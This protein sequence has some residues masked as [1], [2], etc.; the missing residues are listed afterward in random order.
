M[1]KMAYDKK[2]KKIDWTSSTGNGYKT[3]QKVRYPTK[4]SKHA[5]YKNAK[6]PKSTPK[7]TAIFRRQRVIRKSTK[8]RSPA[9]II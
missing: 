1:H 5:L 3:S 7:C 8:K 4:I 2:A 6:K 9:Y